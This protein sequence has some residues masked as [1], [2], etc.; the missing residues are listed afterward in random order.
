MRRTLFTYITLGVV[1]MAGM[2]CSADYKK[3]TAWSRKGTI[4]E[5][6]S[7]AYYFYNREDYEKAAFIFE[8]LQGAY[9]GQPRA[10]EVL[11]RYAY[12]KYNV[13]FYVVSAY[14]FEQYAKQ[15]PNDERTPEALFQVAYCYY[16]ESAPHYLDQSFTIKAINQFQL[17]INRFPFDKRVDQCSELMTELRERLARKAFENA[18]LYFKVEN[19]KAALTAFEAMTQDYPD[20]RY[21]EEAEFLHVKSAVLLAGVSTER[22]KKNRYLDAIEFYEKFV[23]KYPSSVHLKEA[24]GLYLKAKKNLGKILA[25]Q[26]SR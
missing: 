23:D 22:R 11:L 5:K 3:Y 19:Y 14:Q 12:C 7:A 26:A 2:A 6:D 1:L 24:E 17:F 9:R 18:N 4:A 20:S 15:Y 25:A 13:G 10:K 21:R 8:E 16:L